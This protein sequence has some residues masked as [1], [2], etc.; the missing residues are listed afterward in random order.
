MVGSVG[1]LGTLDSDESAALFSQSQSLSMNTPTP[2]FTRVSIQDVDL[3]DLKHAHTYAQNSP[4][5]VVKC[6]DWTGSTTT[7]ENAGT[8]AS[9]G[10]VTLTF[11]MRRMTFAKFTVVSQDTVIGSTVV[12]T[13]EVL[14]AQRDKTAICEIIRELDSDLGSAGK[15]RIR[16]RFD[17]RG[18]ESING[19]PESSSDAINGPPTNVSSVV[20]QSIVLHTLSQTELPIKV[21]LVGISLYNLPALHAVGQNSPICY[22]S[23]GEWKSKT[24]IAKRAGAMAEWKEQAFIFTLVDNSSVLTIT[25]RSGSVIAG[26]F[27]ITPKDVVAIP[28]DREGCTYIKSILYKDG[29][30]QGQVQVAAFLM[31]QTVLGWLG[32]SALIAGVC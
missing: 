29:F 26:A 13:R 2:V 9:W 5:V 17:T 28:R 19:I 1:A 4:M 24:T 11:V 31:R 6:G 3:W 21:R 8:S 25:V 32:K 27:T 7:Q 14:E 15:L 18:E 16:F 30:I 12:S 23:C 10:D 20:E 22:L